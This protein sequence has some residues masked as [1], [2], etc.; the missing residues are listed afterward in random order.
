MHCIKTSDIIR[1]QKDRIRRLKVRPGSPEETKEP[2]CQKYEEWKQQGCSAKIRVTRILERPRTQE[3]QGSDIGDGGDRRRRWDEIGE[4]WEARETD[5][6]NRKDTRDS[7]DREKRETRETG[8]TR[9]TGI[10]QTWKITPAVISSKRKFPSC[11]E[12]TKDH[13]LM[14][15]LPVKT[16]RVKNAIRHEI[17]TTEVGDK[18]SKNVLFTLN[19]HASVSSGRAWTS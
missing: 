7:G 2:E 16:S 9:E 17:G 4:A 14:S 12:G 6:W 8:G 5:R 18:R 15:E 19:V 11:P 1:R 10:W 13:R 3:K